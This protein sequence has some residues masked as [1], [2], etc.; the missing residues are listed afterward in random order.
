VTPAGPALTD[1]LADLRRRFDEAF[2]L[3]PPG[4]APPVED[5]LAVRVAA[6]PYALRLAEIAGVFVDQVVAPLPGPVPELIGVAAFRG[7]L[8]P[9]YDAAVLLGHASPAARR[10][11]ALTRHTPTVALAFDAA[12]GHHRVSAR[13]IAA[14]AAPSGPHRPGYVNGLVRLV[15][16]VRPI[17]DLDAMSAAIAARVADHRNDR[18]TTRGT[19]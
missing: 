6:T 14:P 4:A 5:L 7:A 19:S 3:P 17:L 1:R 13:D 11:L 16:E 15:A 2:T 12:D 8:V 10:W 18:K 9:V